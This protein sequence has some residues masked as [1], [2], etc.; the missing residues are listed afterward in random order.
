MTHAGHSVIDST[1]SAKINSVLV[2]GAGPTGLTGA[3]A[4]RAHGMNVRIIDAKSH[5]TTTSRAAV[6]HARTLEILEPLQVTKHILNR[7]VR[8]PN[9][10][11]R[12][13]TRRLAR[14]DFSALP[15]AYPYTAMIS[16]SDTEDLL[17]HRLAELD[18]VIDWEHSIESIEQTDTAAHA[19]VRRPDGSFEHVTV[20]AVI[21]ADGMHS[22]VRELAGIDFPGAGY[23]QS[24][25]LADVTMSWPV[26]RD[27]VSLTFA[28]AGLLVVA[29][30]PDD[31]FR[32]VATQTDAPEHPT[33]ADV[34]ALLDQ[35]VGGAEVDQVVWS[36]RFRVHH[37]LASSFRA[38]R[39]FLAGDAAHVHSPAGGQ[40]MNTGIQDAIAL[41]EHIAH[42]RD[43]ARYEQ[44]R[45]PIAERVLRLSDRMTR[46]ATLRSR[47]GR[48]ARNQLIRAAASLPPVRHRLT[49]ELSELAY[50]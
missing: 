23:D 30:L 9:F 17:A 3:V 44:Q 36:G 22:R 27:T 1:S 8:V 12:D 41:V 48:I 26:P 24:F 38:G 4:L 25:V 37:R 34:Q 6:V 15:T 5:R 40:G 20:D 45:R 2:V 13:G 21:G 47:P 11:V 42:G 31:R 19:T 18:G 29:P 10:E 7:A 49:M 32:I 50:R 16:Q 28:P 14:L 33:L 46:A 35:R 39:V 43:L